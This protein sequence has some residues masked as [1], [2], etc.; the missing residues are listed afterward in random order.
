MIK[1][2][3]KAIAKFKAIAEDEGIDELIVRA[4]VM[5]GGCS[6]FKYD[7]YFEEKEP[8]EFDEQFEIDGLK[9]IVDP[10]SYQ[11]LDG[12]EID[13]K[14][15]MMASGFKFSNPNVTASC[16]CGESVAF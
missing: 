9:I 11:Y 1:I 8:T 14:D 4:R 13:W 10:L 2:T 3:A 7:L 5:G 15:D 16:G 12:V 6:G